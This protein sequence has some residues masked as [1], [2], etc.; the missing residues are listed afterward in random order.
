VRGVGEGIARRHGQ[1]ILAAI[2]AG[3]AHSPPEL[4]ESP[5][6]E[7]SARAQIW[8]SMIT[9]L[10]QA[11]CL[12]ATI[13]ARLLS[14]R[15]D[16]EALASW[17]DRGDFTTEP[18]IQLLQGWRRAVVGDAALAWLRGDAVIAVASTGME[19]KDAARGEP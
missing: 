16:A 2:A 17:F 14:V 7:L 18:D 15:D 3:A 5:G 1:A 10:I 8:A 11:R 9:S 6:S 13:P 12:S 19:I 4:D